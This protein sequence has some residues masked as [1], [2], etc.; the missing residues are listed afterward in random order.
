M[1][2]LTAPQ[3]RIPEITDERLNELFKRIKP[4]V[5]FNGVKHYIRKCHLRTTAYT[6][7]AKKTKEA[8]ALKEVRSIRTLHTYG[9]YG[10]FK[11]SIAEVIAQIPEDLIDQVTEFEIVKRPLNADDLNEEKR[12]VNAGFH[13]ATVALYVRS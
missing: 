5:E 1:I 9:Y 6:W 7:D 11:P 13:V 8:P 10:F 3:L 2:T 12:A 4:V